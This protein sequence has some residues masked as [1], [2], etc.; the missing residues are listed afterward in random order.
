[1]VRYL[2]ITNCHQIPKLVTQPRLADIVKCAKATYLNLM[3]CNSDSY[4][5]NLKN[6]KAIYAFVRVSIKVPTWPVGTLLK[7][8]QTV[9]KWVTSVWPFHG[10]SNGWMCSVI[11]ALHKDMSSFNWGVVII[12]EGFS[13]ADASRLLVHVWMYFIWMFTVTYSS[14]IMLFMNSSHHYFSITFTCLN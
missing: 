14:D 10:W 6:F 7:R 4:Y 2:I 5:W 12:L 8:N 11:R 13:T 1:M 9:I 3:V